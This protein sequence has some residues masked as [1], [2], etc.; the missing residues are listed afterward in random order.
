MFF[1][2][3][4]NGDGDMV[5]VVERTLAYLNE[6][7]ES[8]TSIIDEHTRDDPIEELHGEPMIEHIVEDSPHVT[9]TENIED[10]RYSQVCCNANIFPEIPHEET[11]TQID[12]YEEIY[13]VYDDTPLCSS[14]RDEVLESLNS[15]NIFETKTL[16]DDYYEQEEGSYILGCDISKEDSLI[17]D[18][19]GSDDYSNFIDNLTCENL[20][21]S[22]HP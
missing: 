5:T 4:H 10:L 19:Y 17:S 21:D 12:T 13:D 20:I 3:W 14:L 6:L 18:I 9:I 7:E 1:E 8:I 22:P 2:R 16:K 15:H 11:I